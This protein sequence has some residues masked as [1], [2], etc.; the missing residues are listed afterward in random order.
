MAESILATVR[1]QSGQSPGKERM[2][3]QDQEGGLR[4]TAGD[5]FGF[6]RL[7]QLDPAALDLQR[8]TLCQLESALT[9]RNSNCM[10]SAGAD[11]RSH[12]SV[13]LSLLANKEDAEEVM[14]QII[15]MK[16]SIRF[17]R[18]G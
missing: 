12:S 2:F 5:L 14:F 16:I 10:T 8:K 1:N 9:A 18:R 15:S 13:F 3:R 7:D 11:G 6:R 4:I 17:N